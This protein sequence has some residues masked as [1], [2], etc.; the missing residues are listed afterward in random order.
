MF[1]GKRDNSV[2][3]KMTTNT[4]PQNNIL[5]HC[6]EIL[7]RLPFIINLQIR[8]FLC[9][10]FCTLGKVMQHLFRIFI[11]RLRLNNKPSN[12][13][14]LCTYQAIVVYPFIRLLLAIL[15]YVLRFT[16]SDYLP[17]VSSNSSQQRYHK[18]I[19]GNNTIKQSHKFVWAQRDSTMW[20]MPYIY[21]Y[22]PFNFC[23]WQAPVFSFYFL[24][25]FLVN[26]KS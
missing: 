11:Y 2:R 22:I 16:D 1:R 3:Q 13:W 7:F 26:K 15:L 23:K 14:L 5:Y 6:M 25:P 12:I 19:S 24:T 18:S 8:G 9:Q 20:P 21:T 4:C 10:N 17:L